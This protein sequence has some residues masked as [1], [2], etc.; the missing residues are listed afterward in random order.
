[1]ACTGRTRSP[2]STTAA[3]R[4]VALGHNGNLTNAGTLRDELVADGIRLGST[5]DTEVIGALIA[6]D[7][8]PLAEAVAGTMARL[9]GAYSVAALVGETLIGVRDS[10]GVRPLCLGKLDG[11]WAV[12][13]ESVALDA[14]G[15]TFVRDVEAGEVVTI[16][17]EGVHASRRGSAPRRATRASASASSSSCTWRGPTA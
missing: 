5:S 8:R 17:E 15:A 6:N 4:T 7:R 16:D 3:A 12:A 11:A 1:M 9:E 14:M 10:L 2:S 13:S